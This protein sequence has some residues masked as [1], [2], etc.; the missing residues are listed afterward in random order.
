MWHY[1]LFKIVLT[2]HA[3][4]LRAVDCPFGDFSDELG[5]NHLAR[6]SYT[7]GFDG[8]MVIHPAQIA[9]SNNIFSPTE[10]PEVKLITESK[11]EMQFLPY[12]RD[13]KTLGRSWALPGLKGF[14]HRVGGLEREHITGNINYDPDNHDL[15]VKLRAKKVSSIVDDIPKTEVYGKQ[16]GEIL[17]L[18]W[19]ST[20]GAIRSGAIPDLISA[21]GGLA[22]FNPRILNAIA[23]GGAALGGGIAGG[24][25]LGA[26]GGMSFDIS[27]ALNFVNSITKIF[28]CD[29]EPECSPND[30]HTMQSGGGSAGKPNSS[31]IAESAKHTS[32][33]VKETKSY[34]TGIAVSYT[35]LTLPT[36]R[37]V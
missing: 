16:T 20:F 4:G 34:E 30:E 24:L 17:I 36:K 9:L 8:K 1:A 12:E 31:S 25:G 10:L 33:S 13:E 14:E 7:M 22:A 5:F 6:S 32:E 18:G 29:P 35:H 26:L 28:N 27:S 37:I 15:M 23:G 3:F 19:G 2:A 21:S 11:D